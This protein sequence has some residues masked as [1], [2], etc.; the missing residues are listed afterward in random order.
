MFDDDDS[1]VNGDISSSPIEESDA[2]GDSEVVTPDPDE[3]SLSH[4]DH[5][6]EDSSLQN[7]EFQFS[8]DKF[9]FSDEEFKALI[10]PSPS[11]LQESYQCLDPFSDSEETSFLLDPGQSKDFHIEGIDTPHEYYMLEQDVENVCSMDTLEAAN[12]MSSTEVNDENENFFLEEPQDTYS[13]EETP[14]H[15]AISTHPESSHPLPLY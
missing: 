14:S 8:E 13:F 12:S 3:E 1:T 7:M 5:V 4:T 11:E 10:S 9:E 15:P 2:Y 6:K